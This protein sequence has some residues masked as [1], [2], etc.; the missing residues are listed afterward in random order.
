MKHEENKRPLPDFV[1]QT[2]RGA[3]SRE[4]GGNGKIKERISLFILPYFLFASIPNIA[5]AQTQNTLKITVNSNADE[6][7]PDDRVTLREAIALA[8][9]TLLIDKLSESE[10]NQVQ[11]ASGNSRIE[12][13]LPAEQTTIQLTEILPALTSPGTI[14]DGT[15]QPGYDSTQPANATDF[16]PPLPTTPVVA[17]TPAP[18]K[19]VFRGLSIV[20]DDITIRGLS[21]YGFTAKYQTTASLPP[22]DIFIASSDIKNHTNPAKNVVIENN[23]LGITPD[24]KMPETP[25]AFGVSVFN[26][27][28]TIIKNNRISYHDGSAIITGFRGEKTQVIENIIIGNG[29]AGMPDAIRL[30]GKVDKSEI[31][32]NLLCANDGSGIFLFKPEGAVEIKDNDIRYNGRRLRRAA[33]YLMGSD[34]KVTN[35]KIINQAGSGV[36]VTAF[37]P[38]GSFNNGVSVRNQIENNRFAKIE[39]L[40]IDLNTRGHADVQDFQRGDGKNPRRDTGN[41]RLDTGNAG[42]N[43]PEFLSPEFLNIN[44]KVNI[45]GIAEPGSEIQIYQVA[46]GGLNQVLTSVKADEKGKFA[47]TLENLKPGSVVSAIASHPKY[48]TSEPAYSALVTSTNPEEMAQIRKNVALI[49][50]QDELANPVGE[51]PNCTTPKPPE[52]VPEPPVEPT[53]EPPPEVIRLRVPNN[54]HYAL[55]KDFISAESGKVL[56]KIVAVMQQYPTIVIE[57]QG[58]TDSRAS[59]AYNKDLAFRRAVNARNY[60]IKKGIAPERMT[61]RSFGERKLKTP[62]RDRVEHAQNR[63][64][65]VMFFDIRGVEIILESQDEDLQIER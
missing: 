34:H 22:A 60:L 46:E 6:I 58:H 29:L 62:G 47:A 30:D 39:G 45:D 42:I 13:N 35:N 28:G 49:E 64:V 9:N 11:P 26:A 52:P 56:D 33:V 50:K 37:P 14:I 57:L 38:K 17:I 54:I 16:V 44:G 7:K 51:I 32:A 36:V 61:L 18:G 21:L 23:W 19:E 27:V 43:S 63:R 40:S 41:R 2:G 65:E 25:S 24:A 20:A 53:P 1:Q 10:K 31:H 5:A 12:F 4:Q 59:D 8:N 15:T 55:N 48:G 3:G